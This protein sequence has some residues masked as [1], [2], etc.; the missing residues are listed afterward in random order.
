MAFRINNSGVNETLADLTDRIREPM[1]F[2]K[3]WGASVAKSARAN[4]RSRGRN[5]WETIAKSVAVDE[6]SETSVTVGASR[7]AVHK[8]YGGD[9]VAKNKSALTIPIADEAKGKT[10][11]ELEMGGRELFVVNGFK[12]D[13]N[14]IGILGYSP[15]YGEFRPLFALRKKVTQKAEPWF[16][17]EAEV[18][19]IGI[20]EA[21]YWLA[22]EIRR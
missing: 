18:A 10:A 6:V 12:S 21:A 19:E 14:T 11:G 8:Q 9:I 1:R 5:F 22:T 15:R 2:L 3:I 13:P 20:K 17:D 4:A 16:P 7:E